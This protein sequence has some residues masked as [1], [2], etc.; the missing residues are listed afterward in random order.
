MPN[1][2]KAVFWKIS[3]AYEIYDYFYFIV[4]KASQH[5]TSQVLRGRPTCKAMAITVPPQ[6]SVVKA[7]S[8]L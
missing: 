8:M 1:T 3:Y 4:Q 5:L 6:V 2:T 7:V